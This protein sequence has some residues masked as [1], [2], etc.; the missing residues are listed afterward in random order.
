MIFCLQLQIK[1]MILH[2]TNQNFVYELD[3]LDRKIKIFKM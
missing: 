3:A 1:F 2:I